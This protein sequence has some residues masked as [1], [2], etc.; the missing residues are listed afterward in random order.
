MVVEPPS[1]LSACTA[2]SARMSR[3]E[4]EQ[5]VRVGTGDILLPHLAVWVIG[6][7]AVTGVRL[8]GHNRPVIGYWPLWLAGCAALLGTGFA[9][10]YL[11][12]RRI[13]EAG[14]RMAWSAADAA[15]RSATV[16]R[17]ASPA[18]VV[19]AEQLLARAE[20][21]AAQRGGR[22]AARAAAGYARRADA[23]WRA[24]GG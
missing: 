22:S 21:I 14:R 3:V 15:I 17:D 13:R 19:E 24:A 11:P 7:T 12:R 16:S 1:R 9:A 6:L 18:T 10:A 4:G 2:P 5:L 8:L 20:S 23:L